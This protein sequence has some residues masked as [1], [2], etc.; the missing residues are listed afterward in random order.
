MSQRGDELSR[1]AKEDSPAPAP[2]MKK[3]RR[4]SPSQKRSN[5]CR[6]ICSSSDNC[7]VIIV[8]LH[9]G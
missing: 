4:K 2:P 8:L 6:L 3:V 1:Q 7:Q 5:H 9:P